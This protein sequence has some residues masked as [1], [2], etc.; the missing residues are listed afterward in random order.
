M[1][2]A[3]PASAPADPLALMASSGGPGAQAA[4]IGTLV[5]EDGCLYVVA[6]RGERWIPVFGF[7]GT[8]W[9]AA[10]LRVETAAG[11]SYRVGDTV[12]FAG[13]TIVPLEWA[14]PLPP[15]CRGN[16]YWRVAQPF[17]SQPR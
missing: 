11:S 4:L 2:A 10:E 14:K 8:R 7:P 13:G 1:K 16:K 6:A 12:R 5:L 15:S 9:N 17:I 3:D